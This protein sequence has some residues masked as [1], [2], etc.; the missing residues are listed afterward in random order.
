MRV[1]PTGE[2]QLA[3]R[4]ARGGP[5][6]CVTLL[7]C[8]A[9]LLGNLLVPLAHGPGRIETADQRSGRVA[10]DAPGCAA[11]RALC[12][13]G[14]AARSVRGPHAVLSP[15]RAA[16][17][18]PHDCA[19]CPVCQSRAQTRP[20]EPAHLGWFGRH[21]RCGWSGCHASDAPPA[22]GSHRIQTARAPPS[23]A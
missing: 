7:V 23:V 6:P 16:D 20:I 1:R 17:A 10:L 3:R 14:A 19:R 22:D 8:V 12:A 21:A 4:S 18:P 2:S 9:A 13:G 15:Y 11:S 5:R